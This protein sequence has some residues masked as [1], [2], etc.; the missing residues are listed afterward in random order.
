MDNSLS[1]FTKNIKESIDRE[2]DGDNNMQNELDEDQKVVD[3]ESESSIEEAYDS[4]E[5]YDL[6]AGSLDKKEESDDSENMSDQAYEESI[7]IDHGDDDISIQPDPS[8]AVNI[9]R[10][11]KIR[12][13]SE[14][15]DE[16]DNINKTNI[17]AIL[18]FKYVQERRQ[19]EFRRIG[20]TLNAFKDATNAHV[21][22]LGSTQNVVLVTPENVSV[23]T[24]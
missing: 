3:E 14:L 20:S 16:L 22:L 7:T 13:I 10:L 6:S 12:S 17:P 9:I 21:I 24:Q 2:Y 23:L 8:S 11:I 5:D 1:D 15:S 19:S 4:Q 18:D